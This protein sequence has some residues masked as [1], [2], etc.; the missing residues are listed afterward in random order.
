MTTNL[1]DLT[2]RAVFK[3][4]FEMFDQVTNISKRC[5]LIVCSVK[6]E[7]IIHVVNHIEYIFQNFEKCAHF[8]RY[9]YTHIL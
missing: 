1:I 2:F 5:N 7:M 9:C 6:V 8:L 3:I 4:S